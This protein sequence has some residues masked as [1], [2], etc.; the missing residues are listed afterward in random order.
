MAKAGVPFKL[1]VG[2]LTPEIFKDLNLT[3]MDFN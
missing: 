1:G 3:P 2:V